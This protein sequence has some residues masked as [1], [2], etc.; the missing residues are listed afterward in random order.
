[1]SHVEL[2]CKSTRWRRYI[3]TEESG[4]I[5]SVCTENSKLRIVACLCHDSSSVL[6]E[7]H[8]LVE[9]MCLKIL[10]SLLYVCTKVVLPVR[11]AI[12]YHN[13]QLLF[14]IE[15]L[16]HTARRYIHNYMS[17]R[18]CPRK[19]LF[20]KPN[21]SVNMFSNMFKWVKKKECNLQ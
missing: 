6:V 14:T 13:L 21:S 2:F 15:H 4:S 8:T 20:S 7:C 19:A 16:L 5:K 12:Y 18:C 1:M 11:A 3:C 10:A 17:F 9:L